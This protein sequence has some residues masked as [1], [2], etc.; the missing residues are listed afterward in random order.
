VINYGRH[1]IDSSDI[2]T[3]LK[4]LKS[5]NITQGSQILNFENELSKKFGSKYCSVVSSGTAGLH[6]VAKT[7]N[8]KKNDII[9]CS[10][11]TFVA[12]SNSIIYQN[13]TPIFIDIELQNY[14]IDP[15]VIEKKL[16]S[17]TIRKNAKAIIATD[18]AGH[19]CDWD[20][21]KYLSKKYNLKLIN[22]NCHAIGA[23]YKNNF[24]YAQ[25]YS[26]F[27]VHSYH[28]VKNMTTGEGGAVFTNNKTHK[29]KIDQLR[30]HGVVRKSNRLY[31]WKYEMTNLGFNYRMT[32]FQ[33]SLGISQLK[34]LDN[35]ITQRRKIANLYN[36]LFTQLD[37]CKTPIV[38][39]AIKHAYHIYPLLIDFKNIRKI[40]KLFLFKVFKKNKINLQVHYIP[41]YRQP[42]YKKK[43]DYSFKDFPN[44]ESFYKKEVSLP[45]F[46]KMKKSVIFKVFKIIKK[47]VG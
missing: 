9:F 12:T 34:K 33:A 29:Q 22:D 2:G 39:N 41:I 17:F 20:A 38:Q 15:N 6:L 8:W 32:D 23:S 40:D 35:F 44:A 3:V 30:T 11:I 47:Y 14:N 26:D 43:F 24:K 36:K 7:L 13:A 21:L 37:N 5:E 28:A 18:F 45:I 31:P 46:Y 19:P 27:V 42:Y 16:Q 25:K 4:S 10:P 1:F